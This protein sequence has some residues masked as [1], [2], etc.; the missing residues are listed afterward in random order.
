MLASSF[1]LQTPNISNGLERIF[2]PT[3]RLKLP[4]L[5]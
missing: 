4:I 1:L 2:I 3:F 5:Y